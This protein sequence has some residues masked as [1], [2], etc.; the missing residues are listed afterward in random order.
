LG[1]A[2]LCQLRTAPRELPAILSVGSHF[3]ELSGHFPQHGDS[4]LIGEAGCEDA[5]H[6]SFSSELGGVHDQ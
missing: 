3:L 6:G 2:R 5:A 4:G 1:P